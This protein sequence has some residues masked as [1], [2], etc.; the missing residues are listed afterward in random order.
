MVT[1]NSA[2]AIVEE[3]LRSYGLSNLTQWAF[4]Q[5]GES[6]DVDVVNRA[7]FQRQEFKDRFPSYWDLIDRGLPARSPEEIVQY[8]TNAR[9]LFRAAGIPE[10]FYDQPG[11]ISGL[12]VGNVSFNELQSRV[13]NAYNRVA[14]APVEVR[15]AFNEYYGADDAD[16]AL[17][18]LALDPAQ[19]EQKVLM[20]ARS[21]EAGGIAR[22]AAG[23]SLM[24]PL[25]ERLGEAGIDSGQLRQ[26]FGQIREQSRLYES[27]ISEVDNVSTDTGIEAT[28]GLSADSARAVDQRRNERLARASAGGGFAAS[29]RGIVGVGEAR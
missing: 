25:A 5:L 8:E 14:S 15:Q 3:V 1:N 10:W 13:S 22:Q 24:R 27:S 26:G 11:E 12:I 23:V 7:L 16:G 18:A 29:E 9:G 28:F 21:A 19:S 2:R 6:T 17:V 4:G 20:K